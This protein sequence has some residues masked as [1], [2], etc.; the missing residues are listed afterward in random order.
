MIYW[1]LGAIIVTVGVGIVIGKH[2]V[3]RNAKKDAEVRRRQHEA[4]REIP[5]SCRINGHAYRPY[6]TG[7][8]CSTCGNFVS[9]RDGELYGL[10]HEG[11]VERR[12]EPR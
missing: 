10:T 1:V 4:L 12:R 5:S 7:Y 2:T 11:R 6:A 9:S 3:A 8:R